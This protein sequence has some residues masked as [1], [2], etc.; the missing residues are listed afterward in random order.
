VLHASGTFKVVSN[1]GGLPCF[2][3]LRNVPV[4]SDLR[5]NYTFNQDCLLVCAHSIFHNRQQWLAC[6]DQQV[7]TGIVIVVA[8]YLSKRCAFRV[9]LT[10]TQACKRQRE[11]SFGP[12]QDS[13]R[14]SPLT[15]DCNAAGI[16][17]SITSGWTQPHVD[18]QDPPTFLSSTTRSTTDSN[19]FKGPSHLWIVAVKATAG[20]DAIHLILLCAYLV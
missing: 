5:M 16:Q 2:R 19:T 9:L 11:T 1:K 15:T 13:D 20:S 4:P 10:C 17:D 14:R 6:S 3:C 7:C 8:G 12:V 18:H